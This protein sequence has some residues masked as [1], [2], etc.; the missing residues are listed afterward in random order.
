MGESQLGTMVS[1]SITDSTGPRDPSSGE[2]GVF[3][4]IP[5]LSAERE[6]ASMA[7]VGNY[8]TDPFLEETRL[9]SEPA[10]FQ[11][12]ASVEYHW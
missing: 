3:F 12:L 1:A 4:L 2:K 8:D 7:N 5:L 10:F 11:S 6:S 9:N